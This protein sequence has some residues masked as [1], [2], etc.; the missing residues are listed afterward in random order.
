[1]S[2]SKLEDKS[3]KPIGWWKHKIL[4]EI[5]WFIRNNITYLRGERMYYRH[6]IK[7]VEKYGINVYG[8]YVGKE[9]Y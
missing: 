3:P 5:G 1:M 8:V 4:C 9:K 6:L 7:M 2:W